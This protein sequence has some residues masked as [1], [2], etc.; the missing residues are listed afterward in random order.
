ML[1]ADSHR[2]QDAAN[3]ARADTARPPP[4]RLVRL[5][6][7]LSRAIVLAAFAGILAF[8]GGFLWFVARVPTG[9]VVLDRNADGIV[10]LTGG[11]SRIADAIELLAA[12]RGKRLLISGVHPTTSSSEIARLVPEYGRWVTC[13]VALGHSAVNTPAMRSRANAGSPTRVPLPDRR[14]VELPHA[15]HHGGARPPDARRRAGA[16]SGGD[17]QDA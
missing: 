4:S 16:V 14:H 6:R 2:R 11:A 13:C 10:V 5:V 7:G 15:A 9:E 1:V 3:A 17:R 8:V 12:G